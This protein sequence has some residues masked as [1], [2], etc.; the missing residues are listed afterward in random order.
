MAAVIASVMVDASPE[1]AELRQ[2]LQE[3]TAPPH[4]VSTANGGG[5]RGA[6]DRTK[7]L[8]VDGV[9][10]ATYLFRRVFHC[11]GAACVRD[12]HGWNAYVYR[13]TQVNAVDAAATPSFR[14]ILSNVAVSPRMQ[15]DAGSAA[16]YAFA[17]SVNGNLLEAACAYARENSLGDVKVVA[18]ARRRCAKRESTFAPLRGEDRALHGRATRC[19]Q[20]VMRGRKYIAT[21]FSLTVSR[22]GL[23]FAVAVASSSTGCTDAEASREEDHVEEVASEAAS[24]PP[25][26]PVSE[27]T[28]TAAIADDECHAEHAHGGTTWLHFFTYS[29]VVRVWWTTMGSSVCVARTLSRPYLDFM[30][31]AAPSLCPGRLRPPR[32]STPPKM[33]A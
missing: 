26:A 24:A 30:I 11:T 25:R 4:V 18:S 29:L 22:P 13:N 20:F 33:T 3:R 28:T 10:V 16:S 17:L 21:E 19:Q 15:Y 2:C 31:T 1:P 9:V 12:P 27:G 32:R 14:V 23:L 6:K 8:T 7:D 5:S